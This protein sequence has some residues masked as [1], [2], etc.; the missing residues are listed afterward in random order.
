LKKIIKEKKSSIKIESVAEIHGADEFGHDFCVSLQEQD[1][2]KDEGILNKKH[3]CQ[4]CNKE[5]V[6]IGGLRAHMRGHTGE[7]PFLCSYCGKGFIRS[8]ELFRHIRIHTNERPFICKICTK[9]FKQKFHLSE[10]E[11][12]HK[13]LKTFSCNE[14]GKCNYDLNRV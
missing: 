11:R 13:K 5:Y 6:Q 4:I 2:Q 8:G 3:T 9:G 14:C 10:H 7:R 12:S 1:V